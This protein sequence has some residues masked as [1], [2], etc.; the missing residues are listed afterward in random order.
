MNVVGK[1]FGIGKL[2]VILCAIR[3]VNVQSLKTKHT[4]AMNSP[5]YSRTL[6]EAIVKHVQQKESRSQNYDL[7]K[8]KND[9]LTYILCSS[10]CNLLHE[11][12]ASAELCGKNGK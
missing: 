3:H 9:L 5:T 11:L 2:N 7:M 1:H 6:V 4:F 12:I 10:V 8:P